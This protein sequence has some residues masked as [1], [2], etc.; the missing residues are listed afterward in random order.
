MHA[1]NSEL[2]LPHLS[3][4]VRTVPIVPG[5]RPEVR[6][7]FLVAGN[8]KLYVKG[9]TYGTFRPDEEG[10]Q[11]PHPEIV[12]RD[13]ALMSLCNINAVRG[14]T[15]PPLWLLDIAQKHN[16][17]VMIGL[18]EE[19]YVKSMIE[20]TGTRKIEASIREKVRACAGHPALLC[21]SIGNE[22]PAP[23]VR[24]LGRGCLERYLERLYDV[25][26]T[27]DPSSLVTYVNYPSTEYLRLPFLDLF[28]FNVYLESDETLARYLTRLHNL[29]GDRPVLMA[30]IGLDSL[31]HGEDI[32]AR[33]LDSQIRTVFEGGCAGAFV[34]SWTDEWYRGGVDIEDWAF[35][36]TDAD[37]RSKAALYRV[38]KAYFEVP[39]RSD[40]QWP[41]VSVVICSYNGARTIRECLEGVRNLDYPDFEVIVVDD[42]SVDST[43]AIAREF[44]VHLIQ[45]ENRGLSSARNTAL[46][47]ASGEIIAYIDDD[48]TPDPH[49]LKYLAGTFLNTSH[50]GVGGPNI[51]PPDDGV[52]A[53]CVANSPGNPAHV[54]ISD[55]LAEHIPGCNIAFRRDALKAIGGFDTQFR[56][57]G[58]DVDVCWRIWQR[59]WT[60]GFC[61]A[62]MV[63]HH[64]RNSIRA[65]WK[66]QVGYGKAEALLE[67]KWPEKYN[68]ANHLRWDGRVYGKGLAQL[69]NLRPSRIYHG[70]WGCA[71]FQSETYVAPGIMSWLPLTPEWTF[72]IIALALLSALG[73][74]W[75]PLLLALPVLVLAVAVR[76]VQAVL[77]ASKASF[78]TTDQSS[79]TRIRLFSVT[80]LL[81]LIQPTARL[82]GRLRYG[83][84]PWRLR[85]SSGYHFPLP[86]TIAIWSERW[87]SQFERLEAIE[88]ELARSGA[89][90]ARGGEYDR[91]DLDVRGGMLGGA[92][93][94]S[95]VEEYGSGRQIT[96]FRWWPKFP[97]WALFPNILLTTLFAG[98]LS[99]HAWIAAGALG[100]LGGLFIVRSLL[101]TS[102][103]MA[104]VTQVLERFHDDPDSKVLSSLKRRSPE[105]ARET[106]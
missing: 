6:G 106:G 41:T 81:H 90:V 68:H 87:Q 67:P 86:S 16:L 13:F 75:S 45:T 2:S 100:L 97:I 8:E 56:V 11:Y 47:A 10:Y 103:A 94:R 57:A 62:A 33:V 58:D 49:W 102:T 63:W 29:A 39:F 98:A 60:L 28:T 73:L 22:I 21:F 69:L 14:Y 50:V 76:I 15:V 66:Q 19:L 4:H 9:V 44:D 5:V 105:P 35:G 40:Y 51:G 89:K 37:R 20:R 77:G 92:R 42:G 30:E 79:I 25:V 91:W 24:W 26:K 85:G 36:L 70:V 23:T 34:Y 72:N 54:L 55:Q 88:A 83:L 96:R 27:E 48:A 99:A 84:T 74:V 53:D 80:A 7:K 104:A 46:E 32:Q 43:T 52:I 61:P 18:P 31:R 78:T 101:D 95:V 17:R 1:P 93:L 59:G 3:E 82:Y 64:R 71:P 12:E 38:S 65:Y